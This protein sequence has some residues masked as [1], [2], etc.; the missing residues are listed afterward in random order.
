MMKFKQNGA[1]SLEEL[2]IT[3]VL[4]VVVVFIFA[5]ISTSWKAFQC[6]NYGNLTDRNTKYSIV[7]GC[8][9][10]TKSGWIP[11]EEMSKGAYGNSII[12]E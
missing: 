4:G 8:F 2:I 12:E 1:T 3:I 5:I 11:K 10:K 6:N 9:V 7:N